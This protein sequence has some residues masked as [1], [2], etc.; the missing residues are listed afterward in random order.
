MRLSYFSIRYAH[1]S[2]TSRAGPRIHHCPSGSAGC[3]VSTRRPLRSTCR[4]EEAHLFSLTA[5]SIERYSPILSNILA[6]SEITHTCSSS[7]EYSSD[8]VSRESTVLSRLVVSETS[9]S[10]EQHTS[11]FRTFEA[12]SYVRIRRNDRLAG[13]SSLRGSRIQR[14]DHDTIPAYTQG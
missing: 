12:P 3:T 9:T 10:L 13:L 7:F 8:R 6:T 5:S 2:M 4:F 11:S 14:A 1:I